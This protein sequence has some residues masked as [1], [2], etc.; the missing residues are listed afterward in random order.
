LA[1]MCRPRPV[2][3][4][5]RTA[6]IGLSDDNGVTM[7]SPVAARFTPPGGAG[8]TPSMRH[9]ISLSTIPPRFAAIGPTLRSLV[10]QASRPEAVELYIPRTYRRFPQW[11]GSLPEVPEGVKIVRIDED[12]GPATKILPAARAYRG[13][14][15]ELLYVDDD[16]HYPTTWAA[17]FLKLR[18]AHPNAAVCAAATTV[19]RMGRD[20]E[21]TARQPQAIIAPPYETQ[22]GFQ[23]HR[24]LAALTKRSATPLT[25]LA[26][27]RKLDQSGY[28][29]IAEGYAGVALRPEFL[30]EVAYTI[31]QVLW[32]V[33]DVWLSGQLARRGIPIWADKQL[34]GARAVLPL[35][36]THP[37]YSAVI[38]GADRTGANL[39]CVDYM[40]ATYG[41][42]GGAVASV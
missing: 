27:F 23:L 2:V 42:W 15:V 32:A 6:R 25:L 24:L 18:K 11:G 10:A 17:Q 12:L 36:R 38:D 13:Q 1:G 31:P 40:R 8:M 4:L 30:D 3:R 19:R 39:A 7:L 22:T 33:D 26:P 16:H 29:D 35:S 20:W 28:A 9:I 21:D 34:N 14:G 41:V 37:L 5:L